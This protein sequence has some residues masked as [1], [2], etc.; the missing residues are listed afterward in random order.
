MNSKIDITE[1]RKRLE[2][3][4]K[5]GLLKLTISLG[6]FSI[7]ITNSKFFLWVFLMIL[8]L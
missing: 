4:T 8:V 2:E 6:F 5:I 7:L 3:N 1:F